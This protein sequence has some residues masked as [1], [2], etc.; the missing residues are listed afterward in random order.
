MID[1]KKLKGII[2]KA[3]CP[4]LKDY[5][6]KLNASESAH[7]SFEIDT[8]NKI[9]I[10]N[11]NLLPSREKRN[12]RAILVEAI[13]KDTGYIVA[14]EKSDLL[15]KLYHY[16]DAEDNKILDFFKDI[17]AHKDWCA[18]RDSLFLR[19]EFKKHVNIKPLK[20]DIRF[21]Y[22]ERGNVISN[23]CTAGYF[24]QVWMPLFNIDKDAF[25]RYLDFA[26]DRGLTALF[27]HSKM[28]VE[29]ISRELK[30]RID[31]GKEYGLKYIHIHAIGPNNI[32]NLKKCIE[33][34]KATLGFADKYVFTEKSL[35]VVV[36]ELIL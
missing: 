17:L 26:L 11:I 20:D 28:N 34:E 4:A 15:E 30:R 8:V 6:L 19:N 27:V 22:G 18:L 29:T 32:K 25:Y 3:E 9:L 16:N 33:K 5:S 23:F 21:K 35:N 31:R 10:I 36:F 1:L 14:N 13:E 24:E 2:P 7:K 12:L